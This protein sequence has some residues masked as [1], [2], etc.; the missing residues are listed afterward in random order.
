[1]NTLPEHRR[2]QPRAGGDEMTWPTTRRH[3]RTL[4]EAF[5]DSHRASWCEGWQHP[6]NEWAGRLLAVA[7]G[8][9]L[10]LVLVHWID[11]S[12]A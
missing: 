11:W 8:I 3:P 10:T 1:M 4:A 9:A 12:L 7:I 2:T 6:H 5:N